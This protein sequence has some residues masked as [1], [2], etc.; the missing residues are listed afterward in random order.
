MM[1]EELPE[2]APVKLNVVC[3]LRLTAPPLLTIMALVRTSEEAFAFR[4]PDRVMDPVPM[5]LLLFTYTL[6]LFVIVVPSV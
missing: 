6:E 1:S 2:R 5:T 4:V 3:P